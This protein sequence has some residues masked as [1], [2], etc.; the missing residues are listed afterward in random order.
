M[1]SA[2]ST[3]ARSTSSGRARR[4]GELD[5]V[6]AARRAPSSPWDRRLRGTGRRRRSAC[7]RAD[8]AANRCAHRA[9]TARRTRRSRAQ[10]LLGARA[11]ARGRVGKQHAVVVGERRRREDARRA[12]ERIGGR[13]GLR[14]RRA[15]AA[16]A[17]ATASRRRGAATT[18]T[19]RRARRPATSCARRRDRR[20]PSSTAAAAGRQSDCSTHAIS[21]CARNGFDRNDAA[22]S[23]PARVHDAASA[24]AERKTIGTFVV[25]GCSCSVAAVEKPSTIGMNRSSRIR[26]GLSACASSMASLPVMATATL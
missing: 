13:R 22:P 2:I 19:G 24:Q 14:R 25:S 6:A 11:K 18:R 26:S 10:D 17:S 1:A 12:P 16:P 4:G 20:G 21:S 8:R 3:R 9:R 7:R 23:S 5:E 15:A